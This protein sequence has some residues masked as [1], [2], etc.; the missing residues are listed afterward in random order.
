MKT[1][2]DLKFEDHLHFAGGKA[3]KLF[4]D[5]GYG[6]SVING[7]GSYTSDLSEWEIA[8]LHGNDKDWSISYNTDITDDV[9]GNLSKE[10]VTKIM[11]KIQNL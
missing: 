2:E 7:Y 6:I 8:V 5:N 10:E 3:A 4:F 9:I 1:F 11:A